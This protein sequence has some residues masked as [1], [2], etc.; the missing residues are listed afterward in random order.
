MLAAA[1]LQAGF[2]ATTGHWR[3]KLYPPAAAKA[4]AALETGRTHAAAAITKETA[5]LGGL[6]LGICLRRLVLDLLLG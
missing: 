3:G 6:E 1:N 5:K 4:V 2:P